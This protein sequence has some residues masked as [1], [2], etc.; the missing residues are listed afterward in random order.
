MIDK[1]PILSCENLNKHFGPTHAVN[2]VSFTL[3]IGDIFGLVGENGAGKS[4]L[5][6]KFVRQQ[7]VNLEK[8]INNTDLI[9]DNSVNEVKVFT[10]WKYCF[11]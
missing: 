2:N 3:N 11:F 8:L 10:E 9:F 1:N 7:S 4:T 6:A 5:L